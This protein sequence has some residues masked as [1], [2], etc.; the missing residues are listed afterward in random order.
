MPSLAMITPLPVAMEFPSSGAFGLPSEARMSATASGSC[1]GLDGQ[2]FGM[3]CVR[4]GAM[5]AA[6]AA[7]AARPAARLGGHVLGAG[8]R[9]RLGVHLRDLDHRVGHDLGDGGVGAQLGYLGGRQRRRDRVRGRQL[10]NAGAAVRP[11]RGH[12]RRLIGVRRGDPLLGLGPQVHAGLL[13]LQDHDYLAASGGPVVGGRGWR[14]G[15]AAGRQGDVPPEMASAV[16]SARA[17][18]APISFRRGDEPESTSGL[19]IPF[20]PRVRA[21]RSPI[22]SYAN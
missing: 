7:G 4:S 13:L 21:R 11:D 3:T 18:E 6:A 2:F 15:L 5:V 17:K 8:R 20:L 14:G 16:V 10:S 9:S 22:V 1:T 12:D 19:P